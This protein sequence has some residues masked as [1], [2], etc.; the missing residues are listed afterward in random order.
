MSDDQ[1]RRETYEATVHLLKPALE[2]IAADPAFRARFEQSPLEVLDELG[3]ELDPATRA[4]LTGK[5]F[6]QFWAARRQAVEGPLE[7]RDLPPADG[8]I[9]DQKLDAVVG[10]AT[11]G[12]SSGALI[13]FAPPYCPVG[14]AGMGDPLTLEDPAFKKLR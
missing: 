11:L 4:E 2:R 9:D 8:R 12:L 6:S 13:N 3:V 14:P 1:K 7:V 10:G 5:R